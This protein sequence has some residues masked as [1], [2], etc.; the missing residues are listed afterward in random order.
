[1][2]W[3]DMKR[4]HAITLRRQHPRPCRKWRIAMIALGIAAAAVG[5]WMLA[6]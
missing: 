3:S 4:E 1:M 2:A 5:V 6:S